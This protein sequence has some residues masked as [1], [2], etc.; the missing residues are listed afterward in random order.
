M[1]SVKLTCII[2]EVDKLHI[3]F[4]LSIVY[5]FLSQLR[6]TV[7]KY[8]KVVIPENGHHPKV[9]CSVR[10]ALRCMAGMFSTTVAAGFANHFRF[11]VTPPNDSK[12][13]K[14]YQLVTVFSKSVFI[15]IF[16]CVISL[17]FHQIEI[18]YLETQMLILKLPK[19][20]PLEFF[21]LSTLSTVPTNH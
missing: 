16:C 18:F 21:G 1:F 8:G 14:L 10:R 13:K 19:E 6:Q 5:F 15:F 7:N 2:F 3:L 17:L 11:N 12:H 20:T 9:C 4:A